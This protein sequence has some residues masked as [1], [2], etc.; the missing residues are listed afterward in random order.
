MEKNI[1]DLYPRN[2]SDIKTLSYNPILFQKKVEYANGK[3]LDL[4]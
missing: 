4:P 2:Y 1:P 3:Y